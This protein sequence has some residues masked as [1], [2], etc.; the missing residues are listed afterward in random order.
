RDEHMSARMAKMAE[1]A[2]GG[3]D[4]GPPRMHEFS[5]QKRIERLT[6]DLDPDAEQEKKVEALAKDDPKAPPMSMEAARAEAKK[7]GEA[8]LAAFE[9]DGFDAK[10]L[11]APD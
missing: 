10:K 4:G 2:D 8:L 3:A 6:R 7:H 9:K 1:R 5:A 11:D